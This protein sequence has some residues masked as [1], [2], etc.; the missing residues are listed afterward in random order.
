[1]AA[2]F[3]SLVPVWFLVLAIGCGGGRVAAPTWHSGQAYSLYDLVESAG[4]VYVASA[5]EPC[6]SGSRPP[7]GTGIAVS[8][9]ACAW[10][11][12][13]PAAEYPPPPAIRGY[14]VTLHG[15]ETTGIARYLVGMP[16][17]RYAVV[18]TMVDPPPHVVVG[19][20]TVTSISNAPISTTFTIAAPI[21][22]GE[23][24]TFSVITITQR[25]DR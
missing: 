20:I 19:N 6:V 3:G 5:D 25:T 8:D 24:A 4:G 23:T 14:A 22:A 21:P 16:D 11:F 13:A 2:R 9:G 10:A 17:Q 1:M 18:I 7:S 12:V 15:G